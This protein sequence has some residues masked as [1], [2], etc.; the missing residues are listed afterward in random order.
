MHAMHRPP[1][2]VQPG[3]DRG[4]RVAVIE[5]PAIDVVERT[6]HRQPDPAHATRDLDCLAHARHTLTKGIGQPAMAGRDEAL[7]LGQRDIGEMTG[8]SIPE[9]LTARNSLVESPRRHD[10]GKWKNGSAL[11]Q[12]LRGRLGVAR[13]AGGSLALGAQLL[14][15]RSRSPSRRVST[16]ASIPAAFA[17]FE[18]AA[19]S[20]RWLVRPSVTGSF[21]TMLAMFQW[22]RSRSQRWCCAWRCRRA[23]PDASTP[24]CSAVLGAADLFGAL[25]HL[26][27]VVGIGLALLDLF[28]RQLVRADGITAG[29]LGRGGVV[30][31]RLHL[32]NVQAAELAICSN[33]SAVLSTSQEAVACGMS[34]WATSKS[35]ETIRAA[36]TG[37]PF[38]LADLRVWGRRGKRLGHFASPMGSKLAPGGAGT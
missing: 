10:T 8:R 28:H 33:E 14:D 34:G 16:G 17:A 27:A 25:A 11:E 5:Q 20:S 38:V 6:R 32:Q 36:L 22:L 2:D 15:Q 37:R 35:P 18:T 21:G 24:A 19:S 9:T 29:Q 4:G 23:C 12:I 13:L 3:I 31:D 26:Q 1:R 7:V 30:R